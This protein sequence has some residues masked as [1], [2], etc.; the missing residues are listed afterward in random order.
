MVKMKADQ[1]GDGHFKAFVFS[2]ME[3]DVGAA[4]EGSL[5]RSSVISEWL[6]FTLREDWLFNST[7][8]EQGRGGGARL[9]IYVHLAARLFQ[10]A[11]QS[12]KTTIF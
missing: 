7:F 2:V 8:I 6:H 12:S 4:D 11:F 1:A 9:I 5:K 3:A 10:L